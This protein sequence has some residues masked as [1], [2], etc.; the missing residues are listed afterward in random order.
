VNLRLLRLAALVVSDAGIV[1]FVL[2][3]VFGIGIDSTITLVAVI[4]MATGLAL[5]LGWSALK[6]KEARDRKV[7]D[8]HEEGRFSSSSEAR[9]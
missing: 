6:A 7:D 8:K 2:T 3:L 4:L 5:Y 9:I 1:L